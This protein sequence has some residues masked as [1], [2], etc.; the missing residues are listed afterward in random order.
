MFQL[1]RRAV[2]R[3]KRADTTVGTSPLGTTVSLQLPRKHPIFNPSSTISRRHQPENVSHVTGCVSQSELRRSARLRTPTNGYP[4]LPLR[5][6]CSPLLLSPPPSLEPQDLVL[7][8]ASA[9]CLL[10]L[11]LCSLARMHLLYNC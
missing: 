5:R 1:P 9:S 6:C 8:P 4:Q 2:G 10:F 3:A 7:L 11:L